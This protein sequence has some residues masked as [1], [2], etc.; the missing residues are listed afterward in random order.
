MEFD[1]AALDFVERYEQEEQA[2]KEVP[3]T[4]SDKKPRK[5]KLVSKWTPEQLMGFLGLNEKEEKIMENE[6]VIDQ[7]ARDILSGKAD[8]L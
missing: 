6:V 2:T 4:A 8:W 1:L 7:L 3:L 5:T